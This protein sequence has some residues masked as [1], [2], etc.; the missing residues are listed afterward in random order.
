MKS[1]LKGE[2]LSLMVVHPHSL[3]DRSVLHAFSL[4]VLVL[5]FVPVYWW[6]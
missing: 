3:P 4:S 5:V 1:G 2:F 6:T